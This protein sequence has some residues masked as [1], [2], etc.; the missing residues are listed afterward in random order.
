MAR[1]CQAHK[2]GDWF[3]VPLRSGGIAVGLVARANLGG[4]LLGY[5]YGPRRTE[6][7]ALSQVAELQADEAILV[8]KFGDLGLRRGT[9]RVLGHAPTWVQAQWPMPTFVRQEALTDRCVQVPYADEDPNRVVWGAE[10]PAKWAE[11][12]PE[13]GLMGAGFIELRLTRLLNT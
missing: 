9:W 8:G 5:F 3:T 2:V 12:L 11:R 10:I 13:D 7:P 4:V 6:P 1:R